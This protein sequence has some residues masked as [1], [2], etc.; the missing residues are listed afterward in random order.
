MQFALRRDCLRIEHRL[1][2]QI[3][4]FD[5]FPDAVRER[6]AERGIHGIEEE[7]YRDPITLDPLSY[8]DFRGALENPVW[9]RNAF[10]VGH[11]NPLKA[12]SEPGTASGHTAENIGWITE[13]GNRIQGHLSLEAVRSLLKRIA[14]NYRRLG[15]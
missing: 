1:L 8:S 5:G 2:L 9:G 12:G 4:S 15:L 3:C 6:L 7:T 14:K 13:D 11:L 10:Q